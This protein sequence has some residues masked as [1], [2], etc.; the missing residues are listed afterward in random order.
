MGPTLA[1]ALLAAA[2]APVAR[3][4]DVLHHSK[5]SDF[6]DE[7]TED[8]HLGVRIYPPDVT[9][10]NVGD[11]IL[12]CDHGTVRFSIKSSTYWS[13]PDDNDPRIL[14]NFDFG[15]SATY[16]EDLTWSGGRAMTEGHPALRILD[17][18]ADNERVTIRV[19]RSEPESFDLSGMVHRDVVTFRDRCEAWSA[20]DGTVHGATIRYRA[21]ETADP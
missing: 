16:D 18:L 12:S 4:T 15:R 14:V 21:L 19:S 11:L 7:T 9:N 3:A 10:D 20:G 5:L 6:Y 1:F 8:R 13:K 2:P 17:E